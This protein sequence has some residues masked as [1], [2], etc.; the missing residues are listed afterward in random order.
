MIGSIF[1]QLNFYFLYLLLKTEDL[2]HHIS[3][4]HINN[5]SL[6]ESD[7]PFTYAGLGSATAG[8][9]ASSGA[10]ARFSRRLNYAQSASRTAAAASTTTS[11]NV[12]NLL[13]RNHPSSNRFA[14]QLSNPNSTG[15]ATAAG[16]SALSA[17]GLSS[18]IRSATN[19]IET[20]GASSGGVTGGGGSTSASSTSV[21]NNQASAA[22]DPIVE[23]LSQLT[24]VRRANNIQTTNLQL[25]QL[26]AQLTRERESLQ[27]SAAA[28]LSAVG[29]AATSSSSSSRGHHHHHHHAHHQYT[30]HLFSNLTASSSTTTNPLANKLLSTKMSASNNP[31]NAAANNAAQ[32]QQNASANN[33]TNVLIN[34]ILEL[35]GNVFLQ[36]L[37]LN[38]RDARLLLAK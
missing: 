18:F 31:S 32:Q 10:A 35:P 7:A 2:L 25:Q 9:A 36:P 26:Q 15:S 28:A 16:L 17:S 27:Q 19:A 4:E 29:S 33:L 14:F 6:N 1:W 38:T 37:P 22:A 11:S 5:R 12:S 21:N 30:H 13:T 20:F 3:L 24:G 23:L 8:A 34:Q